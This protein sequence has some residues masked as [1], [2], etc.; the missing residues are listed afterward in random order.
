MDNEKY[1]GMHGPHGGL[2]AVMHDQHALLAHHGRMPENSDD[3]DVIDLR[4][5]W[6]VIWH[7]KFTVLTFVVMAL[8]A[9]LISTSQ[10]PKIYR[11]SLTM[12]IERFS[13]A[14][15]NAEGTSS[16]DYWGYEDF[17]ETQYELIKSFSLAERV[18]TDLN[19]TSIEQIHGSQQSTFF[20]DW[21]RKFFPGEAEAAEFQT[22]DAEPSET[23]I[24]QLA[25]ALQAGLSVTP[26]K[27]SRLATL[28]FESRSPELSAQIVNA[29]AD[30]FMQ[31]NLERRVA[32]S[33]YAQS[34]LNEQIK[35]V[36]ANLED[37]ESRLVEYANKKEIVNVDNK[38]SAYQHKL[39]VL[40][41]KL[42]DVE[43][44]RIE[45]QA[46]Y[47]EMLNLG[48]KG[49]AL[50]EDDE[51]VRQYKRLVAELESEYQNK[52]KVFKP[53]YPELKQL[54][55]QI[56]GL[57][58][59][60]KEEQRASAI[61]LETGYKA[62][63]REESMLKKRIGEVS[64][65]MLALRKRTTDYRA[66]RRDVETNLALYDSLL[67]QTKEIGVA[68]G[69]NANNISVI[70]Y[71]LVPSG[72]IKPDLRKNLSIALLFGLL[73]GVGLA[74]L[75]NKLD[76]T[77]KSGS[78][79]EQLTHMSVLGIVPHV[80][81]S[82]SKDCIGMLAYTEPTSALAEAYRSFKTALSL[83]MAGGHPKILQIT[84]SGIGEGKTTT[85][86]GVAFT[87]IQSGAKV[88]L[89]DADLRNPSIHRQLHI[90]NE[91]GLTNY[92]VG[93]K[94]LGESV[95]HSKLHDNL[96]LVTAGPLSPNPA[97][98]LASDKMNEFLSTAEERFDIVIVDGPPVLGL[99]DSLVLSNITYG[100][101]VVVDAGETRKGV[102]TDSIKRLRAVQA[103]IIGTIL[104]KYNQGHS[105]YNYLYNY[106]G[107]SRET[108]S[109]RRLAS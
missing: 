68:A 34:F 42:L 57:R 78:D 82:S 46:A 40:N 80:E 58:V 38:L 107:S 1:R 89:I 70:D 96:F 106:Y 18:A 99:A 19:L 2:P 17:Y 72:P 79:L 93:E 41:R 28:S 100:T 60:I 105:E 35:Q 59:K 74:F 101:V 6:R 22:P 12:Q 20:S 27:N 76:D 26:V 11:S 66:L 77:V 37:S 45:A 33:T 39:E 30:S 10:Q 48:A 63:Q 50:A 90:P 9:S 85:A 102:L 5:Y 51:L 65:E 88:L 71:A 24:E 84:S 31:V 97:E 104:T 75:F 108:S 44:E 81:K 83:S 94:T 29:Y 23:S 53:A 8:I 92:L 91:S 64:A 67:Q 61:K 15:L 4:E 21:K 54:K 25:G 109:R 52:L 62:A 16:Y 103:N 13:N 86:I 98:L 56:D 3:D 55:G 36:R 49:H 7:R 95:T 69:I 87:F 43:A 32:D 73:G 14:A 47:D